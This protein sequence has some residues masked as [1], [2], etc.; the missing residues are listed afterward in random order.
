MPDNRLR[1]VCFTW[2]NYPLDAED[3]LRCLAERKHVIYMVV[4]RERGES[5]TPHLQGY[6][7]FKHALTFSAL[8]RLLPSVHLERARGS[9]ADNQAYC[10][11][12]G[13]FFEIGELPDEKAGAKACKESWS[14][15]LRAAEAGDWNLIKREY[16]RVW[17]T[18]REKLISMRQP[19]SAVIDGD[20][21]NE[22]WVGPTGCGKSRLA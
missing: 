4:G 3:Q 12:D 7:H 6:V 11:K 8:K 18:F 5:G 15:I 2:N 17:I 9:G 16:P 22:W 19:D 14:R 1:R 20:T 13:D 21:Q 10:T